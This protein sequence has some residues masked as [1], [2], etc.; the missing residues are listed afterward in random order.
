VP[1]ANRVIPV[2]PVNPSASVQES[3]SV[4]N[5]INPAV[6]ARVNEAAK[7]DPLQG[8]SQADNSSK[9]WTQR[10]EAA[11][12]PEEA[13]PKEPL[14]KML[15]DHIH[16]VWNASARVVEIWLQNNPTQNPAVNQ[17]VLAQSQAAGRNADPVA[18]PGVIAKEVLTY[19]PTKIKKAEKP[20]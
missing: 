12:K 11:N 3:A 17:Q 2:A 4:V 16:S 19:S 15:L 13:P 5:D 10:K 7:A 14:S 1:A 18:T 20:E 6:Q 9:G 8:G